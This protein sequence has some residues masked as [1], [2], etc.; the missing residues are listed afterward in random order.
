[1]KT[2]LK[3][4]FFLLIVVTV[5][6]GGFALGSRK[7]KEESDPST[8]TDVL[9]AFFPTA[10]ALGVN[11]AD[12]DIFNNYL[13][14]TKT[15]S[16]RGDDKLLYALY[17]LSQFD[18]TVYKTSTNQKYSIVDING[19]ALPDILYH[20]R[21]YNGASVYFFGLFLNQGDT[22]F[23]LAYKCVR[24]EVSSGTRGF[25]GDCAGSG[26]PNYITSIV[27]GNITPV[28]T[29]LKA[30][31]MVIRALYRLAYFHSDDANGVKKTP[32]KTN[33]T[34]IN[35]DGLVDVLLHNYYYAT[36]TSRNYS[37]GIYL[38]NGNLGFDTGYKCQVTI[39]NSTTTYR[40]DCAG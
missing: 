1:M 24:D 9:S 11:V 14:W 4:S 21:F 40:G 35:G 7:G 31:D 10:Q 6:I 20:D 27:D 16:S 25:Y 28:S 18:A 5:G 2:F 36:D 30:N 12:I 26:G 23:S 3:K 13:S 8:V 38:N 39:S 34:D 33:F 37:F 15:S 19:D 32:Q 29:T 22:N 17:D